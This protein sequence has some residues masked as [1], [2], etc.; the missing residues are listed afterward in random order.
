MTSPGGPQ[1]PARAVVPVR[2]VTEDGAERWKVNGAYH[3]EDGPAVI[4]PDGRQ[5]WHRHGRPHRIGG[6][7]ILNGESE[8]WYENGQQHRLDG[9]A[10]TL[11]NGE[12]LWFVRGRQH[13]VNGPAVESVNGSRE[14]WVDDKEIHDADARTLDEL[15]DAGDVTT[16]EQTLSLWRQDGPSVRDLLAA[17]RAANS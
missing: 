10:V 9:P 16:I 2:T 13:R 4:Y 12:R 14:W 7:A 11:H 8:R 6:P 1:G 5:V 15:Y 17:V 3:R